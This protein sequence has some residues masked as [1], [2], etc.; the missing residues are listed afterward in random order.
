MSIYFPATQ[1]PKTSYVVYI[2]LNWS[3]RTVHEIGINIIRPIQRL[4]EEGVFNKGH[5]ERN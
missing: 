3:I 2:L 5:D 4:I 1:P